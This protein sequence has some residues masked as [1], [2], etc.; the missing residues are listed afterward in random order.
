MKTL[1]RFLALSALT[2]A[3]NQQTPMADRECFSPE[4]GMVSTVSEYCKSNDP[5]Q[6]KCWITHKD[7]SKTN[8]SCTQ[9]EAA[10]SAQSSGM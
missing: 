1:I 6:P 9:Y 7:T 3:C 5:I 2:V 8:I 10:A 4:G